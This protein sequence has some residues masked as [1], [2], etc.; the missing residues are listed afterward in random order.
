MSAN[1]RFSVQR[2]WSIV[3][4]EFLQLRRD[5]IT[6][7]MIVGLP[8]MQLLLFGFAINSDPRHMPTA[9]IVAEHSDFSR[10]FVHALENTTYFRV[11][12]TLPDEAAG[13]EALLR[14]DVQ[15]VVSI[16]TDFSRKLLRG[17][18]PEILVEADA[19][20]PSATGP[21]IG[22][23]AQLPVSVARI[24]LKGALAA[25]AG[26]KPAFDVNVQRL[27]NPEGI[28]QYNIVP[29]LMGV[30]LT[31]TMVMMTGLAMT[32]ERERGTMENLLA[33]P[34]QPLEVISGKIVPYI[35]IGLIQATII[36]LAARYVFQVPFLGSVVGVYLAALLFIAA[37]LTVGIT[38][39]SLAKNQ[40][41][42]VQLTFFYFLPNI[43]LS[44]FMFPFAGMPTWAQW[45]GNVLP[46]TYFNRMIRSIL[47]KGSGWLELWPNVWP[48][49][50]FTAIVMTIAVRFYK[51]TLD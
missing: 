11:V 20:D 23:L 13:R 12:R 46:M 50:L 51:R 16:P 9:V 10:T 45:I 7:G 30:I 36:L 27:Y 41:Q 8:I 18:R 49:A 14:G 1:A 44:G 19:T 21:A 29:G 33:T 4:K 26:G 15:F 25:L 28:T 38:L 5:R 32:R 34:V 6:F 22:A 42:A 3:L 47:L 40:L 43:L 17:E 24:D 39:S 35:F 37:N 31:M 48:V 2:W